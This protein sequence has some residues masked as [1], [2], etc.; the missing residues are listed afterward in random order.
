MEG[1]EGGRKEEPVGSG[2]SKKG[3]GKQAGSRQRWVY[4]EANE[5]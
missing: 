5:I 3:T 2:G 4:Y 1:R